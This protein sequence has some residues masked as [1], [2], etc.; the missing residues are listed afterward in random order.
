MLEAGAAFLAFRGDTRILGEGLMDQ[1]P[2][3][4]VHR[5]KAIRPAG[6]PYVVGVLLDAPHEVELL[7]AAVTFHVDDHAGRAL[8]AAG[9]NA[10]EQILQVIE[11]LAVASD[12]PRRD[13]GS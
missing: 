7:A 2:V 12:D 10:V 4:G 3:V 8:L 13:R 6:P 9:Q 11:R 5:G 1:A